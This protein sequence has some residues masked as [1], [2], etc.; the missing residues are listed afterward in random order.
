MKNIFKLIHKDK[1]YKQ[2]AGDLVSGKDCHVQGLW[3]SSASFLIAGLANDG[4]LSRKG[5]ILFVTS[6]IDEAEEIFEDINVFLPGSA[7]FFP[8]SEDAISAELQPDNSTYVQQINVLYK[9]LTSNGKSTNRIII[10]PIQSLLQHLPPPDAIEKNIL[11]IRTG[12][13]YG[14][15]FLVDWLINGGFE[16]TSIVELP[17]EFSLRGGI[18]DVFP[19]SS[20]QE[21]Q[22]GNTV[23]SGAGEMPYR[24]EFFGD[25]IDSIRMFNAETQLSERQ[26]K[27]CKILGVQTEQIN[28]PVHPKENRHKDRYSSLIDYIPENSWIVFKEYENIGNKAESIS[29]NLESRSKIFS[30]NHIIKS[31]RDF[32]KIYLSNLT[33]KHKNIF[34]FNI[35][36]PDN[37]DHDVHNSIKKI[38][39]IKTS[40]RNTI[41]FYS[42]QAEEQRLSE[43]LSSGTNS[44]PVSR[45]TVSNRNR[46]TKEIAGKR[47]PSNHTEYQIGHL[48]HGFLFEDIS[49]AFLTHH[50]IFQRY[51]LRREPKKLIPT[52]AIDSFLD[53]RKG[54]YVVHISHGIARFLGMQMLNDDN[55]YGSYGEFLVLEFDEGAKVYVPAAKIELVQKYVCGSE[56]KPKL[57]K[58]GKRTWE[59]KKQMAE[60]AVRDVASDLLSMQAIREAKRGIAYPKDS[61]WQGKFESEF[62]YQETEDQLQVARDIKNDME[63]LKPMDRLICGD[64]GYGK[65]EIAIRAAFKAVMYGKQV[66]VLVPTTL[67]AQQHYRT[68]TERMADYPI[69]IDVLSRFKTRKEQKE[70]L[71]NLKEGKVDIVIGTHRLIQKDVTFKDIGLIVIDEEQ[72]F[73][74][75]HKEKLKK[76]R[77]SV[78]VLTLTATPI[79]RTLHLSLLGIKDVSS[80]NTPPQ[81]RQSIQT[82]L[83]RFNSGVIK[84]AIIH[85]LNRDGQIYFVHNRVKNINQIAD[86]I[87]K[88]V[89]KARITVAHGQMPERLLEKK[90]SDFVNGKFDILV[91]TTI[92]ESGLD[93]PNVNTIFINQADMF[94]LADLHQL[95]G[96][97]GRYKHR[98]YAYLLLPK[99][100]PVTPEAEKRL[101]AIIDFS[102]LGSGFKIAMRDLEI[103]GTGNI[104]GIEQHGH[105]EAVGYEMFCRLLEIVIR[106]AKNEPIPDYNDVHINLNLESY[107]PDDYIPDMKLKIEIY[108]KINRLSSK[109]E[110]KKME[111][112]LA[113]RFGQIPQ[114]VKNLLIES[115]V[116]VAAQASNIRSLVRTNGTVIFHVENLKKAESLF[117]NAKKLVKVVANN[118]L[119]LALPGKKMSPN[120]SAD[121]ITNLL[122]PKP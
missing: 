74:V 117:R 44:Q 57:S 86:T 32:R 106:K 64:V 76:F 37:F 81:D 18:I 58:L 92:I 21:H 108:R 107:L 93:I 113:D 12:Q 112:E 1:Q 66:A 15:E 7:I 25:E 4:K 42:N 79:P 9:L 71:E 54:D 70:I 52:K 109:G 31:C 45:K 114:Q 63:S 49:T 30:F 53:V 10:T 48:N 33:L 43:L 104:L 19:F 35:K 87:A 16:R 11:T 100:R 55:E 105:I 8:V 73:G 41:I 50:E 14:Q 99:N 59:R 116:R 39:G 82:S 20:L 78:D 103:R 27:E 101:K 115:G 72:R 97:V 80:L 102:E 2:I 62:I 111:K 98:A 94:G 119:H 85:E 36:A 121:F 47:S 91:S 23:S 46:T 34:S 67:L 29:A 77:E 24:I 83:L 40:Y 75:E 95:R 122:N 65:T 26:V 38:E 110:I 6:G 69:N 13:E 61:E 120:D 22:S 51:R 60:E 17:G 68:F 89:P 28:T 96:R 5:E 88:I 3:G 84:S 90:T 56:H 118:E